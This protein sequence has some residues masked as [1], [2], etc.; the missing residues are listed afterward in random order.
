MGWVG[1]VRR[2]V[3]WEC[4][5]WEGRERVKGLVGKGREGC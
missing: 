1:E 3:G 4:R 5:G 2:W